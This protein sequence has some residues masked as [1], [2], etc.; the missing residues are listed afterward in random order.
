MLRLRE[1]SPYLLLSEDG[2]DDAGYAGEIR[3]ELG[4]LSTD[5]GSGSPSGTPRKRNAALGGDLERGNDTPNSIDRN[6]SLGDEDDEPPPPSPLAPVPR[7]GPLSVQ[8]PSGSAGKR[9]AAA[10]RKGD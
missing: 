10:A 6:F 5:R 8:G 7:P 4:V 3:T 9:P 2:P 1:D